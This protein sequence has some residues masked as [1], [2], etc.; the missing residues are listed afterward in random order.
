MSVPKIAAIALVSIVAIPILLGFGLNL[1]ET[2]IKDYESNNDPTNVTPLLQTS[3]GWSFAKGD[4]YKL[5][6]FFTTQATDA[7]LYL[8][9]FSFMPVYNTLT[10]LKTTMP[11]RSTSMSYNNGVV[12][13]L[14]NFSF[15]E[16]HMN[17]ARSDS[18]YVTLELLDSSNNVI[19]SFP[20]ATY[21]KYDENDNE[22]WVLGYYGSTSSFAQKVTAT[23][24]AKV[25]YSMTGMSSV[26]L[27][28]WVL[29]KP[30]R[31]SYADISDGYYF[32]KSSNLP[33][34]NEW[35]IKMPGNTQ[36]TI[37]SFDLTAVAASSYQFSLMKGQIILE[38]TT[39]NGE[40]SW[41]F[42]HSYGD[43]SF[44]L[45]YDPAG[46]TYQFVLTDTG[47]SDANYHYGHVEARYI[48]PWTKTIGEANY[49]QSYGFDFIVSNI[50]SNVLEYVSIRVPNDN[51]TPKMRIDSATYQA[52]EYPIIEDQ[53]YTPASFKTNPATT[54]TNI[55]SYG[56]SIVFGGNT[57]NVKDGNI[58]INTH[59]IPIKNMILDS[60][61]NEDNTGYVNRINGTE[62]ST[63][64]TPSTITLNGKWSANISTVSMGEVT[65][66]T[67]EWTPGQ[68][69][70]NGID[71]N[72]LMAGLFTIMGVFIGL[73]IYAKARRLS[74]WP[75]MI[76]C[77]G[78]AAL[79]L[80]MI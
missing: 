63:T 36:E 72:F 34:A 80:F 45:Y 12:D 35:S 17:Y 15:Y 5:N 42:R 13:P 46:T 78:A 61:P 41:T 6:D 37:L 3:T 40:V 30:V 73:G 19:H 44:N 62:I 11:V 20:K 60:I 10:T 31:N 47:V 32:A 33:Q 52:F 79:F 39:T 48:G 57:Y 16:V 55:Q 14:T 71:D 76:V 25:R 53:T 21:I 69:A 2:S 77:G 67:T 38:K 7:S 4:P 51:T 27:R 22:I 24:I 68:F 70:W 59:K 50:Y 43:E 1:N 64:A 18:V 65:K 66:T 29:D 26:P 54:I 56:S 49:Y 28:F 74:I 75:L 8:D 58:T 9:R 23:N